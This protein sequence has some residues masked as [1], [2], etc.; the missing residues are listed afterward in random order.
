MK[1]LYAPGRK[2]RDRTG[3]LVNKLQD[4]TGHLVHW[5]INYKTGLDT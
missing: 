2:G 5:F 1:L 3:H 4:R